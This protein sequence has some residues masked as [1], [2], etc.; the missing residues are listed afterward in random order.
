[1]Q[2]SATVPEMKHYSSA[3][4]LYTKRWIHPMDCTALGDVIGQTHH[5]KPVKLQ[6]TKRSTVGG[7]QL[8]AYPGKTKIPLKVTRHRL[9]RLLPHRRWVGSERR[10]VLAKARHTVAAASQ[11]QLD[12]AQAGSQ[13]LN[14]HTETCTNSWLDPRSGK[15]YKALYLLHYT[16][17]LH[18]GLI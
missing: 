3:E 14:F 15:C 4:K 13:K 16:S 17:P 7:C 12:P 6:N 8:R 2:N 1:M 9:S 18:E 10:E 11:K 5:S